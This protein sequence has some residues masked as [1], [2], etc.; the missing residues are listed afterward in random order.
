[1]SAEAMKGGFIKLVTVK[2]DQCGEKVQF[3]GTMDR[4]GVRRQLKLSGWQFKK[5]KTDLCP[6]CAGRKD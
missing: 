2:C 3:L 4:Q 6:E 1:M 5:P